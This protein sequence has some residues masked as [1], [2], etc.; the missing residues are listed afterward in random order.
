MKL[1]K[2]KYSELIERIGSLLEQG[3]KQAYRAVNT[4][5]VKTYWEIG[6]RIVE[7]E[8]GGKEKA[9][10]YA[11]LLDTLSRDLKIKYGKLFGKSNVYL[12]REFYS[13]YQKFQTV[14]GKLSWS[15]YSELLY[16]EKKRILLRKA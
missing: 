10:Y 5:L 9:D 1:S 12:M 4:V 6:K 3:R 2:A 8:Q 15:H 7:Y 14:S 11:A 13:K 16:I